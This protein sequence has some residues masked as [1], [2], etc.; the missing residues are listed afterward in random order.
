MNKEADTKKNIILSISLITNGKKETIR[1][2]LDSVKNIM[3]AV[4]SE[5]II[6]DTG[7]GEN[8]VSLLREY[9][10]YIVPFTWC[11]DFAKAR[12]CGLEK[13]SGEWF[14]YIDDDE[15]F[16]DV[17]AIVDFFQT[18]EYKKYGAACYIQRNYIG[19]GGRNYRDAW[20]S[21][22]VCLTKETRFASRIHEYLTPLI[23]TQ[24][25]VHSAVEHYGYVFANTEEEQAHANRNISILLEMCDEEPYNL[26]CRGQLAQEYVASKLYEELQELC[27]ASLKIIAQED[28]RDINC[29]RG[30]FYSGILIGAICSEEFEEAAKCFEEAIA[31][32]RNT[33]LCKARLYSMGAEVYYNL[34]L[35]EKCAE[36]CEKYIALYEKLNDKEE[37]CHKQS[38]FFVYDALAI[39]IR[40]RV[41]CFYLR[42][43]TAFGKKEEFIT[44]FWK[45][46]W[47]AEAINIYPAMVGDVLEGFATLPY[48]EEFVKM[49]QTMMERRGINQ[50]TMEK[51]KELEKTEPQQFEALYN[52]F[53][54][55][56]PPALYREVKP[57]QPVV[58]PEMQQ[59]AV[60]I[61]GQIQVLLS[62]NLYEEANGILSQLK[63]F[64]PM[65]EEMAVMEQAIREKLKL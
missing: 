51:L 22:M 38:T 31:D 54:K 52:I 57:K 5:L 4:P 53:S 30:A 41:Y 6:V 24:K 40:N 14:M 45:L 20:V 9:T 42:C 32:M 21:R 23:G 17:S 35:Y 11:N 60:Q 33:D 25:L 10:N 58:S 16:E 26:H 62:Q 61:K 50:L 43:C 12:N 3:E 19:K 28:K 55:T 39:N 34:H 13:A 8:V 15:W 49:A 47:E 63:T 36:C 18:G 46:G 27:R 37:E 48:Q 44:N 1:K 65:D 29:V 7:C 64:V 59:L 56:N 2:C